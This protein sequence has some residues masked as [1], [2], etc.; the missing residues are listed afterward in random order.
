MKQ[1]AVLPQARRELRDAAAW[2]ESQQAGLGEELLREVER[3]LEEIAADPN[4]FPRWRDDRPYRKALAR[5]FPYVVF[6]V[7]RP[8]DVRVLAV[9]HGRR[10]PGYWLTRER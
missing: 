7:E 1:L 4:R 9:A 6:F 8:G 10:R 5:R 3:V 2:Y